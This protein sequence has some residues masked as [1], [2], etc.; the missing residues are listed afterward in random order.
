MKIARS[1]LVL[2]ALT[3]AGLAGVLL[4]QTPDEPVQ[5]PALPDIGPT[6][7]MDPEVV[8]LIGQHVAAVE[9]AE[10]SADAE[11]VG[12][13]FAELGLVYEAN[14][15]WTP[16]R[17]CYQLAYD[18][19]P[20]EGSQRDQWLY[21]V[22]VCDH[23]LGDAVAAKEVLAAVAPKLSGTAIVQARLATVCFDLGLLDEAAAAWQAAIDAERIAWEKADPAARAD[24]P[25]PIPASR[26]GLAQVRL[27]QDDLAG[28]EELLQQALALQP[29]YPHA[30][31]L[32]GQIYA[33][34]GKEDEARFELS[35]GLNA[36]PVLPPD[37]HAGRLAALRA[38]YGNRM[39]NIELALQSGQVPQAI[40]DLEAIAAERPEDH[41]VLNLLGRAYM[42]SG[43][44]P[45]ALD[46]GQVQALLDT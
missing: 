18:W 39:R 29:Q 10:A 44:L 1:L 36:Y 6:D 32:L 23:A 31:Y 2:L 24:A 26:V 43:N 40:A 13:A 15:M 19:I 8:Q 20:G 37:P 7:R 16:A 46:I 35:R 17:D 9:A 4:R 34:Q 22:G 30:H 45:K 3:P 38:G 21:R 42:M 11:A 12:K 14:T 5:W 27:E 28:A 25:I 33:E 41:L